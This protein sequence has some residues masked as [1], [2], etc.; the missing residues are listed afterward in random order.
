MFNSLFNELNNYMPRENR[1]WECF[2]QTSN[3]PCENRNWECFNQ[4]SNNYIL[5]KNKI[6]NINPLRFFAEHKGRISIPK[7]G[8]FL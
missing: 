2:N 6:K 4:T 7:F 5:H 8:K 1:N 3:M